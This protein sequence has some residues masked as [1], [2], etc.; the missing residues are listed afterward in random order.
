MEAHVRITRERKDFTVQAG[1]LMQNGEVKMTAEIMSGW[2]PGD[3]IA[4]AQPREE[5]LD[6]TG[7]AL[8]APTDR[9]PRF[10]FCDAY[11]GPVADDPNT[12]RGVYTYPSD[13]PLVPGHFP[14]GGVMMGV[15]QWAAVAELAGEV[16]RRGG[17]Q[18]LTVSGG[19]SRPGGDR[20]LDVRG[21][22]ISLGWRRGPQRHHRSNEPLG[23]P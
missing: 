15:T 21:L 18:A 11:L 23:L 17:H 3:S 8:L 1:E 5:R 16:A 22:R 4:A 2:A 13:H 10:G 20:V 12:H 19:L 9:D 14:A 6:E 7:E